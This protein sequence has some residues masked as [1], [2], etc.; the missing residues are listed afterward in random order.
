M[1]LDYASTRQRLLLSEEISWDQASRVTEIEADVR[2]RAPR[3]HR[4]GGSF[5]RNLKQQPH[6][7]SLMWFLGEDHESEGESGD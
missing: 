5:W 3:T 6:E 2:V 7:V 1:L 4:H